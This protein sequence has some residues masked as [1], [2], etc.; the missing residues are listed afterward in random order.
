M[1]ER[2]FTRV[3]RQELKTTPAKFVE[4]AR[5]EAACQRME[6]STLPLGTLARDFGFGSGERLRRAFQ[7][8]FGVNP[9]YYRDRF[10]R[11]VVNPKNKA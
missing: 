10:G 6:E 3:F 5:L 8:R 1:S 2:N 11:S 9:D 4:A 7:R